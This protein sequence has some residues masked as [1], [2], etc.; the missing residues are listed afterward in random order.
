MGAG[1]GPSP[2]PTQSPAKARVI[3]TDRSNFPY[4]PQIPPLQ[5]RLHPLPP[6]L[7]TF[8]IFPSP[9]QLVTINHHLQE[10][11]IDIFSRFFIK[12]QSYDGLFNH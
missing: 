7:T 6:S 10:V 3:D 5:C 11:D 8:A 4:G 9:C 1:S 2:P 12:L